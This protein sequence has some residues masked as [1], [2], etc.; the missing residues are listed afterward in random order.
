MN[1]FLISR[2]VF[3]MAE[4][5]FASGGGRSDGG[6]TIGPPVIPGMH[7]VLVTVTDSAGGPVEDLS[8]HCKDGSAWYNYHTNDKG[9]VLFATNSGSAN[10]TAWNLS[11]NGNYKY[12]DQESVSKNIDAPIG[13]TTMLNISLTPI[14]TEQSFTFMQSNIYAP[15]SSGL[16]SGN[17]RVRAYNRANIF[18]GGAGGGGGWTRDEEA[19]GGGGGGGG[20][21]IVR[22]GFELNQSQNYLFYIGSGGRGGWRAAGHDAESTS[23][24]TTS[25]FGL[26]A[27]G[28]EGGESYSSG[29]NAM[30]GT[31]DYSGG[32]SWGADKVNKYAEDSQWSNWGGGGASMRT[33]LNDSTDVIPGGKPGG[34]DCIYNSTGQSG[35]NGGGGGAGGRS[36]RYEQNGGAGS[37]GKISFTFY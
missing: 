19:Y 24:G 22:T 12:L 15:R 34:G 18:L 5:I 8:V 9:Q 16:Y 7:T 6:G 3:F 30:G 10:I 26:A 23:G 37:G 28:G 14:T 21:I 11:L 1:T 27:T 33:Y 31:G 32:N 4:C 36:S 2:K 13:S 17:C 35:V 29:K 25:G 20:G